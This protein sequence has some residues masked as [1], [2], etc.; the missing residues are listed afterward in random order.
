[1]ALAKIFDY[2]TWGSHAGDFEDGVFWDVTS[3]NLLDR[4]WRFGQTSCYRHQCS[5][6]LL[7]KSRWRQIPPEHGHLSASNLKREAPRSCITSVYARKHNISGHRLSVCLM[8]DLQ[9]GLPV[10]LSTCL[11]LEQHTFQERP[12]V[13]G[14]WNQLDFKR[15]FNDSTVHHQP[16]LQWVRGLFRR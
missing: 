1:M 13:K 7:T 3:C 4:G 16:P 8:N 10:Y 6:I 9:T 11:F 5:C 2:M 14:L 15:D 12:T